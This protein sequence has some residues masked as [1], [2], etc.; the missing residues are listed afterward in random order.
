M[1]WRHQAFWEGA[2]A[3]VPIYAGFLAITFALGIAAH[4]RGLSSGEVL[5][6]SAVVFA[7]PAQF[8]AIELLPL[9]GHATQILL[10]TIFINLRFAV[11]SFALAPHFARVRTA[12]LALGAQF[13][14]LSTFALSFLRFQRQSAF[15][16]F[17]YFLGVAIPSYIC[18]LMGTV[19]GYHFGFRIPGGFEEGI[20]FIFPAYLS[21][22]LAS[23]LRDRGSV[24]LV[25]VAFLATPMVETLV[26][27]WGLILT[28]VMV[29]T[30]AV[31]LE[32]WWES[33]SR[34]S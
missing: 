16:N 22:L 26:P 12:M 19:V 30:G 11:M 17:P 6:M 20:R 9:G 3:A 15:D 25:A 31:G 4:A 7:A 2:R 14:S 1:V 27:G 29:A 28:A 21:A 24:L 13:I 33:A 8:P 23:E 10:G 5:L 34:S 18:Y 32:E